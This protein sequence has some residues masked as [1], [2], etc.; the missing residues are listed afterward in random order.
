MVIIIIVISKMKV[1][2]IFMNKDIN[3]YN[4]WVKDKNK[5]LVLVSYYNCNLTTYVQTDKSTHKPE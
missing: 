3:E 2:I 5:S 4:F 1:K